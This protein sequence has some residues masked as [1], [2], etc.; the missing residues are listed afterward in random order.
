[1]WRVRRSLPVPVK[2]KR[3][4][5]P[6]CVFIFGMECV[7]S[8]KRPTTAVTVAT[9]VACGMAHTEKP[10]ALVNEPVALINA[11]AD[12]TTRSIPQQGRQNGTEPA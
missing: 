9:Y 5:A 4:A 2:L 3:L 6:L 1:M 12:Y 8:N 7:L 10:L 11:L